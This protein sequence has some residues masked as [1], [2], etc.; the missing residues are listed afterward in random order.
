MLLVGAPSTGDRLL[1]HPGS[2]FFQLF[3]ARPFTRVIQI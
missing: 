3:F 1:L 2:D